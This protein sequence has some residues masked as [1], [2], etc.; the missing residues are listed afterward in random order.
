MSY[1]TER[2]EI[3]SNIR[4]RIPTALKTSEIPIHNSKVILVTTKCEYCGN[5]IDRTL[6]RVSGIKERYFCNHTNCSELY[7]EDMK[8][9]KRYAERG[10]T[11]HL[12]CFGIFKDSTSD[13]PLELDQF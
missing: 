3:E 12:I 2:M 5:R 9:V 1:K 10:T 11:C 4:Y 13:T 8:I 6:T 7:D